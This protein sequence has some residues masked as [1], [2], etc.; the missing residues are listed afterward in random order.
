MS[1]KNSDLIPNWEFQL[2]PTV[3]SAIV[4]T[5]IAAV[6]ISTVVA[7]VFAFI[8]R[9]VFHAVFI[10]GVVRIDFFI[11]VFLSG[12]FILLG[13]T[14]VEGFIFSVG[15]FAVDLLVGDVIAYINLFTFMN[16]D[17]GVDI[18]QSYE[19]EVSHSE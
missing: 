14:H 16:V 17:T 9:R 6:V 15:F 2:I 8:V 1:K 4:P 13:F 7:H 11:G 5:V 10:G 12:D 18:G 19:T 3:I